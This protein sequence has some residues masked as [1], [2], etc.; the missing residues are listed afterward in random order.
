M[1][2]QWL[3]AMAVTLAA[4]ATVPA[5]TWRQVGPAGGTVI[6]LEAD[7]H[8][9]KKIYLGTSDGHVFVSPD[10]GGHWQLLSRIGTGQDDVVTHILVD[11]RDSNRLYAS[12][13]TLYSGGGGVYRSDDAGRSWTIIGLAK[14]TVRA[15]AQSPTHPDVFL[16]GS[17]TGVYRSLDSGASW[18]RI[19]PEHHDDLRNFDSVAFDP[20]D[21][22]I[23]YAGTYHLPW[24][25]TDGG[26]NWNNVKAGMIDDSDVM[27]II[28]DP[29]NPDNVH[30]TACSGIYHS[31]NGAQSWVKYQGIPFVFRRTQLIRQDPRDSQTLYAGT[32]SGLWKTTNDKDFKRVTPGDWVIN[33]ILIDP[34]H[35][36]RIIL[37]T[38]REGVQISENAGSTF[39]S[40]N[41]GFHHQHMQDVAIDK[42][43]ADRA[44]VV[45]TFD[46]DAFLVTKDGGTSWAPLGPGL[47]R[48]DLRHVY[49]AP[50]GWWAS[51]TTGGWMKY[52]ETAKKWVKAG[53]FV[54]EPVATP[55]AAPV[56][57]KTRKGA[58]ATAAAKP[59]PKKKAPVPQ[60]T[61]FLV[62]DM[63]FGN[64]AWYAG[65]AG[66]L[67]VSKDEGKTWKTAASDDFVR[68]PV[69]SL[70]VS[71]D[72]TQVW[73]VAQKN[74]LYSADYGATWN[75]KELTFA[76]AGNLKLHRLDD[77]NLYLTSNMGLYVSQ[78]AGRNWNRA[79]VRE[80]QFQDVAGNSDALVVSLQKH[81]LLASFDAGKSWQ[82][83]SDPVADSY[84]P[85]IRTRRNGGLVAASA[86][87]GLLSLERGAHVSTAAVGVSQLTPA[88][89]ATGTPKQ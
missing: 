70:E 30:A 49:A 53:L 57:T 11:A 19:T 4:A 52:D 85:V 5:Q 66:G 62:N 73:A 84:F 2:A 47:K 86:T 75:A 64:G 16:A 59:A 68:Q 44:L 65:T 9:V 56:S 77:A 7:P 12:T 38:E 8:D 83:L 13:W 15:L 50:T 60:L 26:K 88:T 17:L 55:A 43:N 23:I 46:T 42:E 72:G 36:D 24:K 89:S 61:A 29:N 35:P 51:L 78:D 71:A 34:K 41:L 81:G 54:P 32:T 69:Q 67:L 33:A 10:E 79:D 48:T 40:A 6:T 20:H 87:E 58:A 21:D 63:A 76:A 39:T 82:R 31:M 3:A 18:S 80:L 14:E 27:S 22:N 1:K 37:G 25:T 28:V 45:L 74:L